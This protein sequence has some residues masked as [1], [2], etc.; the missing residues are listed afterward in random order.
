[1]SWHNLSRLRAKNSPSEPTSLRTHE[2]SPGRPRW[3][4]Q[5]CPQSHRLELDQKVTIGI[6]GAICSTRH[7]ILGVATEPCLLRKQACW[8][9][10]LELQSSQGLLCLN[11]WFLIM[12]LDSY[13]E[14]L[15]WKRSPRNN[16]RASQH[17]SLLK[18]RNH[19]TTIHL[20]L[21]SIP[22]NA[23]WYPKT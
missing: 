8:A 14:V 1:M 22:L 7:I 9:S 21:H 23:Q 4:C 15:F 10:P 11:A 17:L 18:T 2:P 13:I 20:L 12:T 19:P 6:N 3:H 5:D 16:L